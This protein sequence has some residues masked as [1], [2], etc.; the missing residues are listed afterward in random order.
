M[1]HVVRTVAR[2]MH[3]DRR[4]S[5]LFASCCLRRDWLL[6]TGLRLVPIQRRCPKPGRISPERPS[7]AKALSG[8][9][10]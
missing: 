6:H 2:L 4:L 5:L 3:S 1:R 9:L 10:A 8:N 7:R